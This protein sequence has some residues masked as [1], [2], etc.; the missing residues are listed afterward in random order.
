MVS[1]RFTGM[2]GEAP[3]GG[4]WDSQQVASPHAQCILN[5]GFTSLTWSAVFPAAFSSVPSTAR[6]LSRAGLCR[7]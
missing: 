1:I 3:T 5:Y 4:G 2:V 7:G 6:D